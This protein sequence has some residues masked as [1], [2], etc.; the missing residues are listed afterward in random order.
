MRL[1][2]TPDGAQGFD[3]NRQLSTKTEN[4]KPY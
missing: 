1:P 3:N 4:G 2:P